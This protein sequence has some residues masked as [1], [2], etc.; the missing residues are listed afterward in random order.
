MPP[1]LVANPAP[2]DEGAAAACVNRSGD[3]TGGIES[4]ANVLHRFL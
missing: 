3:G 4:C 1:K 2:D